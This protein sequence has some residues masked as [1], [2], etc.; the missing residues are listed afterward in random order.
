MEPSS[1]EGACCVF[2]YRKEGHAVRALLVC[3]L[4]VGACAVSVA[5]QA[6]VSKK[7]VEYGWDVPNPT[8]VREHIREMEQRPF[9]GLI[10]RMAVGGRVF[11]KQKWTDEQ[12]QGD[13][14][15]LA[16]IEWKQFTDN[17]LIMY[18]ASDVDWFSDADWEAVVHNVRMT[19]RAAK[20]GHCVGV[21]FDAEPYGT[22]PWHYP[23]Q[24][25]A[26]EKSFAEYEAK[27][28]ERGADF[29][30]AIQS[31]MPEAVVHTFF[32][33]PV[34][35]HLWEV[36]NL[37]D[38]QQKL[39]QEG[40]GLYAAFINGMLDAMQ[41]GVTL[42]DGN[43]SAY[44]YQD[45]LSFYRAYH[46][47]RQRALSMVAPENTRKY[48]AQVQ[49]SQALYVDHLFN[50]RG[51]AKYL[52]G[53]MTPE[54]RAQWFEH[55][56]FYAL[57]CSDRYVWLYSEK[58]NWWQNKDIPPGLEEATRSGRQKVLAHQGLGFDIAPTIKS[59]QDR[60]KEEIRASLTQ[61]S[62]EI[63]RLAGA[64]PTIDG[65]LG[66]EA[67]KSVKPL[68]PLL[69]YLGVTKQPQPTEARVT[70]DAQKLYVAVRCAEPKPEAM[71]IVGQQRDDSVWTG[72]SVDLFIE[73]AD[74][75]PTYYHF[76]IN[77]E[78]VVW[79]ARNGGADDLKYTADLSSAAR[80]SAGEWALEV[81]VPWAELKMPA[82]T[83]GTTCRANVCRQRIPDGEQTT[84]SQTVGGFVEPE[85]FGTWTFR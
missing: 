79:D 51:G 25:H 45:T 69:P 49:V 72:D 15:Q 4:A 28:R 56:V 61:R 31:E 43:E 17:F 19:A 3:I 48:K 44:Y 50:L 78:N 68:E 33:F 30:N 65:D 26:N 38:R 73:P 82:P 57:T 62:A 81:A 53:Y 41:P 9:D 37:A 32:L 29:M 54:E 13:M 66:D 55:N 21:C 52:S 27:Y 83:P 22:N 59:A 8:F 71:S 18:A 76:I 67:W 24:P 47:I 5:Q 23:A 74:Q 75:A 20:T 46:G 58:M 1:L 40:Y 34:L 80:R 7:L 6:P 14:E 16:A 84:W 39:S 11:V 12:V 63:A 70:Y 42:T 85:N 77:P 60:Q 64:A 35:G 10:M 2:P 36:E